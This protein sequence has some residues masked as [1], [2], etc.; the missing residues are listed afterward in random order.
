MSRRRHS[1]NVFNRVGRIRPRRNKFDLSYRNNFTCKM[2]QLIPVMCDE[3]VPGDFFKI[4]NELTIRFQPMSAPIMHEIT[5]TVHYFFVPYRIL[6]SQWE[7]FIVQG[8][9]PPLPITPPILSVVP[10]NN[11]RKTIWDYIGLPFFNREVSGSNYFAMPLMFPF[12]AYNMIW[13]EYYRDENLQAELP[14]YYDSASP[15]VI[16]DNLIR[17]RY[18][19]WKK[20]YFTAALPFRQKGQAPALP[21]NTSL[22]WNNY[23]LNNLK[24][25]NTTLYNPTTSVNVLHGDIRN[26]PLA[27]GS[28][29]FSANMSVNPAEAGNIGVLGT[30]VNN[31][32]PILVGSVPGGTPGVTGLGLTTTTFNVSDLRLSFQIQ[33]WLERNARAGT[34]Y[35]SFLQAHFGVS[36]TDARLD[37]P[38]YIGGTKQPVIISEVL[39]TSQTTTDPQSGSPLAQMAGHG[40]GADAQY[41][42]NYNVQ[43]YGVIIGLLSVMPKPSY[44]QGM[45]R[46]W[47]RRVP[48]DFY[49]PEFSHLSEQGI[50]N[51]ELFT[52]WVGSDSAIFGY[53]GQYDEMRVKHDIVAGEMRIRRDGYA[54][55]WPEN[56]Q[57]SY[58]NLS[59]WF[60]T[61]PLLNDAFITT[62][63]N[64]PESRVFAVDGVDTLIVNCVNRIHAVR[65]LPLIAEPGLVDHF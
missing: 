1:S 28:Q 7:D 3:A 61:R 5:A 12:L 39:Q 42:G 62:Q 33:K 4:G 59:R 49:F 36:P 53:T 40:L 37:R 27:S 17:I 8:D 45:N 38:E 46:Q 20:D 48:S 16:N 26:S 65:P 14:D 31:I 23:S 32:G 35:T 63:N 25:A 54:E 22:T 9:T 57:L 58:W 34:R 2:G 52:N 24:Y 6:W 13:N 44:Q 56:M 51:C 10:S 55:P 50:Y 43:E 11:L 47:L 15:P 18:R 19:N 60:R 64:I 41:A 21:V 30:N 29:P